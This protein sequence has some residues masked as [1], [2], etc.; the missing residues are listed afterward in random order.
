LHVKP[1]LLVC[2]LGGL[3]A[4]TTLLDEDRIE[5]PGPSAPREDRVA[6]PHAD[7]SEKPS[8]PVEVRLESKPVAGGYRLT[9]VATPTRDVAAMELWIGRRSPDGAGKRIELGPTAA[10][11]RR[12]LS[13]PITVAP[14]ESADLVGSASVGT[15]GHMRNR[16]VSMHFGIVKAEAPTHS[17]TRTLPDGRDVA[18]VR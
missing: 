17:V 13:V 5:A 10:G 9:L 1:F 18:E 4:C 14:G 12:E 6:T 16:V 3:T 2:V 11:Q 15:K 7:R 8:A